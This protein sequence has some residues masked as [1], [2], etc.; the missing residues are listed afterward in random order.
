MQ[1]FRQSMLYGLQCRPCKPKPPKKTTRTQSRRSAWEDAEEP[2]LAV[3][4]LFAN[5]PDEVMAELPVYLR[6]I[7]ELIAR[8]LD[9]AV[10]LPAGA[11]AE[12]ARAVMSVVYHLRWH[13][14]ARIRVEGDH[15]TEPDLVTGLTALGKFYAECQLAGHGLRSLAHGIS[16]VKNK[17]GVITGYKVQPWNG[18]L[19]PIGRHQHV[20][21]AKTMEEAM[22]IRAV[23][24]LK[25]RGLESRK[26]TCYK[27]G[28]AI[29]ELLSCV[30]DAAI[31]AGNECAS[32]T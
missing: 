5:V 13:Q 28:S 12:D 4:V 8:N 3:G 20:G 18:N 29:D 31:N 14:R 2:S 32:L 10:A 17:E 16:A 23:W 11:P 9:K 24:Y 1:S 21:Y 26:Y 30:R 15:A 27:P 25:N 19:G 22:E 6:P 7:A